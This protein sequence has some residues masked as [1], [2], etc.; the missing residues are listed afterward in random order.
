MSSRHDDL[1]LL[2]PAYVLGA[3]DLEE[4]RAFEAHLATCQVCAAEVRS[5][6]RVTA[7]LAQTPVQVSPRP[8]VRDR[9]LAA[10]GASAAPHPLRTTPARRSVPAAATWLPAAAALVLAASFALYAWDQR[11]RMAALNARLEGAAA[12]MR[13]SEQALAEAR[14]AAAETQTAIAVLSAPDLVRI[15]LAGQG[16]AQQ[17]SGRALWSRQ[18]GMVFSGTNL[19]PLPAGRVYQVW[20]ITDADPAPISAGLLNA[21]GAGVFTTPPD[22]AP[23]KAV[24]VTIEPAPGV[25]APTTMPFLVGA[26]VT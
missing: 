17:A 16:E 18:R 14:R 1:T 9:V 23:P 5:L 25:A 24:A 6:A 13:Q 22:I 20:V 21:D 12:A 3:L 7:G 4:R 19:P 2:A 26:P 15:D 8:E 11:G 10:V